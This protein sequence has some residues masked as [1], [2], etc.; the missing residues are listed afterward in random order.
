MK[1]LRSILPLFF[2]LAGFA[3]SAQNEIT[4]INGQTIKF[5]KITVDSNWVSF[6]YKTK[7]GK[8]KNRLL[9]KDDVFSYT[10]K[11]KQESIMYRTNAH[12]EDTADMLTVPEMRLF[13][14]G[15]HQGREA[16]NPTLHFIIGAAVGF[17]PAAASNSVLVSL[18][19]PAAATLVSTA[20]PV[21]SYRF[22][23]FGV[24]VD[25]IQRYGQKKQYK[26]MRTGTTIKAS[27]L[28]AVA[29]FLVS[30]YIAY[31]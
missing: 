18:L 24:D 15:Q 7:T 3:A 19:T 14:L 30:D 4:L 31:H 8:L 28:G 6:E 27:F 22:N 26:R 11:N 10:D 21:A 9:G 1:A 20:I 2:F 23:D 5:E 13:V 25:K 12:P 17:A 16:Y 29:G